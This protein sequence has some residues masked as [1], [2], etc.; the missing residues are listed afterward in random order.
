[1]EISYSSIVTSNRQTN[2]RISVENKNITYL[3]V[4]FVLIGYKHKNENYKKW[5]YGVLLVLTYQSISTKC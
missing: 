5:N 1:M 2:A 3:K 4:P